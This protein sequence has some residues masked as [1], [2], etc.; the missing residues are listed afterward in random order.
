MGEDRFTIKRLQIRRLKCEDPRIVANYNHIFEK[1]GH[2]NKI[3]EKYREI[4]GQFGIHLS[5]T[6][7]SKLFH[8]GSC[9]IIYA[10]WKCRKLCMGKKQV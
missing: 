5:S 10:E 6:S 1:H 2:K 9:I 7:T 8:L 3:V 4:K